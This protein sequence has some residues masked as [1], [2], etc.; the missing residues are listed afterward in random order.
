MSAPA[1]PFDAVRAEVVSS[2]GALRAEADAW[3][4]GGRGAAAAR[5][6][7]ADRLRALDWDLQDLDEAVRVAAADPARFG[8]SAELMR[9]R[10][11]DVAAL[12][13]R[14]GEVEAEVNAAAPVE[15]ARRRDEL[16]AD[17]V[18]EEGGGGKGRGM[19]SQTKAQAQAQAQAQMVREQDA[20]LED[21]SA[22]VR[23]IG[24]MGAVMHTELAEQGELLDDLEAGFDHT[25]HRMASVQGRLDAFVAE[26]S[27][28]QLCTIA[29]LFFCFVVL[30][31]LL[32]AT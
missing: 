16:L 11:E 31:V 9:R 21:L 8:A 14:V 24:D 1:D 7:V 2:I 15:A 6:A 3:R 25:R 20:G 19:A 30:T 27:R 10:Q 26:A 17:V 29:V 18:G 13:D 32:L 5:A 28:G 4:A 23:R 12:R 22:A